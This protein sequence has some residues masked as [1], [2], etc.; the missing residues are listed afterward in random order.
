MNI[1]VQPEKGHR[2]L[3]SEK[4][5][6]RKPGEEAKK[7]STAALQRDCILWIYE[8][9]RGLRLV[10]IDEWNVLYIDI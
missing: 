6:R 3:P 7:D 10:C 1:P 5:R 2:T 8:D 9:L 4:T